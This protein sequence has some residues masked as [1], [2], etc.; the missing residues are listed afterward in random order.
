M[1]NS[2]YFVQECP[3]C[4]RN[5]QIRVVHMG[6][7]VACQH[8]QAEF[9]ACDPCVSPPRPEESGLAMINRANELLETA[10]LRRAYPR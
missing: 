8:C 4:G 9:L 1:S 5:L 10:D 2:T 7:Q 6:R 3:T